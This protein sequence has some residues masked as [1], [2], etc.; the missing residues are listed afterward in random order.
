MSD[1]VRKYKSIPARCKLISVV[2]FVFFVISAWGRVG[3]FE[4]RF[5]LLGYSYVESKSNK[6]QQ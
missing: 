2:Y 3:Q 6:T 5:V 1:V 4:Y